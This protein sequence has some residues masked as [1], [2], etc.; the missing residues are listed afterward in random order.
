MLVEACAERSLPVVVV[1]PMQVRQFAKTQ[2]ILAK[3]D[4][5]DARLIGQFGAVMKPEIR[6]ISSKKVRFIR[7]LLARKRQLNEARTQELNRRHK[8]VKALIPSHN[9]S[10]KVIEKEIAWIDEKP[11]KAV[12]EVSEWQRQYD[13]LSSV[14]DVGDGVTYTLMGELPELGKLSSRQVAALWALHLTT[15]KVVR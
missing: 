1:Q 9:R 11:G 8:A 5:I 15:E 13:I 12:A 2:G 7:D 10:L 4:K 3:T 6:P 14:P